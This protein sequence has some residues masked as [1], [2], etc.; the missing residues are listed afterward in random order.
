[1]P[2]VWQEDALNLATN[3]T[4]EIGDVRRGLYILKESGNAAEERASRKIEIVDVNKAINKI[5]EMKEKTPDKLNEDE[6]I[7]LK[8]VKENSGKKIGE[9]FD[10]YKK[11]GGDGVYK[12]FQRKIDRLSKNNFISAI[13]QLG[14]KEGTTTIIN[15]ER[16][17]KLDE[18]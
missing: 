12:T 9:L 3:K 4:S 7:I 17:T 18:Y 13:T 6:Q 1:M 14:G 10:L 11:N 16:E 8:I 5:F 2:N 15:Y